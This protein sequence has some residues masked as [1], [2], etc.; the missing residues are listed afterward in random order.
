MQLFKLSKYT[1]TC[2][3][4]CEGNG[5]KIVLGTSSITLTYTKKD[6][7]SSITL[8]HLVKSGANYFLIGEYTGEG[9]IS[10]PG[11]KRED[12]KYVYSLF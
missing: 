9:K 1:N 12:D 6:D 10:L 8:R 5:I 7:A 4:L 2:S 11:N 3:A